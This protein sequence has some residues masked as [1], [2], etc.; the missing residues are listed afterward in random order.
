MDEWIQIVCSMFKNDACVSHAGIIFVC[1]L[2]K[3]ILAMEQR[4][5]VRITA[6]TYKEQF[7]FCCFHTGDW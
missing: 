5:L 1:C 4:Y 6:F 2:Q 3:A 7:H